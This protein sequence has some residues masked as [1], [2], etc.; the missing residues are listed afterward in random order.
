MQS[1]CWITRLVW[2]CPT[3]QNLEQD[4][5]MRMRTP[6]RMFRPTSES[7]AAT[8]PRRSR[9]CRGM[10]P[11]RPSP[12]C[13]RGTPGLAAPCTLCQYL[14]NIT[15]ARSI[16]TV[17]YHAIYY[18]TYLRVMKKMTRWALYPM[19]MSLSSVVNMNTSPNTY[20]LSS[21]P[22]SFFPLKSSW[23]ARFDKISR[24]QMITSGS[25]INLNRT[26]H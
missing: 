6:I 4:T 13:S 14:C 24:T 3:D 8:P 16:K 20:F 23:D 26:W 11:P 2:M 19:E 15:H 25:Q 9:R 7:A 17:Y 1:R 12:G 5:Q 22:L 18:Y 10:P 21:P